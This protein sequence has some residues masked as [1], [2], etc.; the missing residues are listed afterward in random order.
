MTAKVWDAIIIGGGAAGLSAAQALGR[1]LRQTL[2]ID[3]GTPR[4]RFA[5]HMHNVLGHDGMPPGSLYTKGR[6][7]AEGYGV[8]FREGQVHRVLDEGLFLSLSLTDSDDRFVTRYVV[9]ATGLKD[10][11][12]QIPGLSEYWGRGVYQCPYCHGWEV[13]GQRIAVIAN[14]AFG[15]HQTKLLRQW[16]DRLT[17]FT[18]AIEPLDED[19]SFALEAR[20]VVVEEDAVAEVVGDGTTVSAVRTK[21]G[22][23]HDVD[24][25]FTMGSLIPHDGFLADLSLARVGK[26]AGSFVSVDPTGRT[27]HPRVWAVGNVANPLATVPVAAAGGNAAGGAI[28]GALTED[29][30]VAAVAAAHA[31]GETARAKAKT[32]TAAHEAG[33]E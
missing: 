33:A 23:V 11:L 27:S 4:N 22:T 5:A 10:E 26:V 8:A 1:S 2:V 14:Q 17:S 30:F 29:D 6:T 21:G 9:V 19:V 3:S 31:A 32:V 7:E 28:N 24:A 20:G 12:P 25:I 18:A 13:R 16:T 15:L